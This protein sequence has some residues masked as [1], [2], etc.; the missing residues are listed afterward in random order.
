MVI[1]H[2]RLRV[3]VRE[4]ALKYLLT[5]RSVDMKI[6]RIVQVPSLPLQVQESFLRVLYYRLCIPSQFPISHHMKKVA[7]LLLLTR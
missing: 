3:M 7:V 5:V 1:Y 6:L 2:Q 4:N